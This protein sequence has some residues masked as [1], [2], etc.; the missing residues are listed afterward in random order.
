MI[1]LTRS[2]LV[3]TAGP[4][5]VASWRQEFA[6]THVV[7]WPGLL[8]P[9]LDTLVRTRLARAAFATRVEDGRE[10]EHTLDDHG[11]AGVLHAVLNDPELWQVVEAV[12]GCRPIGAFSGRVYRREARTDGG[13]YFPWHSDVSDGRLVGF[14]LNLGDTPYAGGRLQV[15]DADSHE[16]LTDTANPGRGDALLFRIDPALEHQVT[17]VEGPEPRTVLAGWFREGLDYWSLVAPPT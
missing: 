17:P 4:A 11:L 6:R 10:V 12:T 5:Q 16:I 3:L 8:A 7:R 14:S 2:A 15:R 9:D 1:A 13:H